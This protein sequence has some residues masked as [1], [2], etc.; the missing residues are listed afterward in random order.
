MGDQ[1]R[2]TSSHAVVA[3]DAGG[4]LATGVSGATPAAA[5]PRVGGRNSELF[6]GVTADGLE[7]V[8][9]P[10]WP[11]T[12]S[13]RHPRQVVGGL[14]PRAA[15]AHR[16]RDARRGRLAGDL[17]RGTVHCDTT[18]AGRRRWRRRRPSRAQCRRR[19]ATLARP[20]RPVAKPEGE[21]FKRSGSAACRPAA[22]APGGFP[23][24]ERGSLPAYETIVLDT[25]GAERPGTALVDGR[26]GSILAR[27]SLTH[28]AADSRSP[29]PSPPRRRSP[30]S[31]RPPT[32]AAPRST[33]LTR[34][35]GRRRARDRV[36]AN[37]DMP[38][39][40]IVL[41]CTAAR[42]SWRRPTP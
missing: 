14:R 29:P 21:N 23:T 38:T 20:D 25:E 12:S 19:R 27:E 30:A 24:V 31:S 32:A 37:A 42:R 6:R 39:Q 36:F 18:L 22:H 33:A 16:R 3:L 5:A 13:R 15:A 17:G 41:R 34:G 7:L 9:R 35:R 28:N 4:T 40:E 2:G 26:D 8:A 1:W 11:A 10:P